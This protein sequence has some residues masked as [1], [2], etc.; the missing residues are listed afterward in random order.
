MLFT[1]LYAAPHC[2]SW[3]CRFGLL[4]FKTVSFDLLQR[5][6]LC[7]FWPFETTRARGVWCAGRR[8]LYRLANSLIAK[9]SI[10]VI[11]AQKHGKQLQV[12]RHF[13]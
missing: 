1:V 9:D 6:I 13:F 2:W 4:K 8:M 11:P 10:L 5:A 12:V 7:F 3:I